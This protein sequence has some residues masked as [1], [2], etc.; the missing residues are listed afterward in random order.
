[1][2]ERP[3]C[4]FGADPGGDG[5][6]GIAILFSDGRLY[7]SCVSSAAEAVD[8][9]LGCDCNPV[10]IGVDAP[11]WWS[12]GP[13]GGRRADKWLRETYRIASGTVQSVNSLRGAALAQGA[14]IVELL[15]QHFPDL[16]VTESHPKALLKA[17]GCEDYR[18]LFQT[19][20]IQAEG[21]N[22]HERDAVI[23]AVCARQGFSGHWSKDLAADRGEHEQ[24][25]DSYWLAPV[26]YWWPDDHE[27]GSVRA[28]R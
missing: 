11:L 14:L 27:R 7:S 6:F 20:G 13:G 5:C 2:L 12:A 16:G 19:W 1:M 4:W 9:F 17:L 8:V 28:N 22:E 15:R 10:A 3:S 24:D 26:H 23:C 25:T 21:L 18:E